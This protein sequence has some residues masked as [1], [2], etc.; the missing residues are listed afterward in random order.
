MIYENIKR[1]SK[2]KGRSIR[3]IEVQAGLGNG[4]IRGWRTSSPTIDSLKA[5]S[6]VLGVSLEE[7]IKD[8][9]KAR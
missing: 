5:V 1:I 3:S 7:L 4:V 2:E 8:E 6:I 9:V